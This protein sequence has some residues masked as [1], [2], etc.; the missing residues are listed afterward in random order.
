LTVLAATGILVAPTV[1][2]SSSQTLPLALWLTGLGT[3]GALL[4]LKLHERAQFHE[5]RA[6]QLR[7]RLIELAPESGAQEANEEAEADHRR[8]HPRL[9]SL[10]LNTLLVALNVLAALLGVLHIVLALARLA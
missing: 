5:R 4:C 3:V 9:S 10:R 6:R 7:D 2:P 1:Q 8:E